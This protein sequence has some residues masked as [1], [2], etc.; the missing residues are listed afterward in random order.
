MLRAGL[1]QGRDAA[2]ASISALIACVPPLEPIWASCG[3]ICLRLDWI[4]SLYAA[5]VDRL[6]ASHKRAGRSTFRTIQFP[7][8]SVRVDVADFTTKWLYFGRRAYEP[9]TTRFILSAL[10]PGDT[11]L[12]V[13]AHHGYYTALAA[14]VVGEGGRVVAF[15]P[16]P[17]A[18]D[19]L[20]LVCAE[21][22]FEARVQIV[23]AAA[24]AAP[25]HATLFVYPA[26]DAFTSLIPPEVSP[27]PF[28][29][30][31]SPIT[32]RVDSL[33]QWR[34]QSK[35]SKIRGVKIDVEKAEMGVLDGMQDMLE[36]GAPDWI[37]CETDQEGPAYCRLV[38]AGYDPR[39]LDL[40]GP[41]YG[42][43]LFERRTDARARRPAS[44][45]RP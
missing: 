8:G 11:F 3:S 31:P 21:N 37:V 24:A 2:A 6:L 18:R 7:H 22:R 14:S 26:H 34:R 35:A 12:D 10:S 45:S 25:G 9:E 23:D 41:R 32:V 13:G 15:E 43:F 44:V 19:A 27:A 16:M 36:D 1:R 28:L 20:R 5:V 42:N 39:L 17:S 38:A 30:A 33:D 40:W 4:D 29:G